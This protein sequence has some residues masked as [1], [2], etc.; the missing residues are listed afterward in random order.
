MKKIT[1]KRDD[2]AAVKQR[3]KK[4]IREKRKKK[5]LSKIKET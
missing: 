4:K 1:I 5:S 3:K 2:L